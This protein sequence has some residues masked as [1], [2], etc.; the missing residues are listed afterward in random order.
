MKVSVIVYDD[1]SD[2]VIE[3]RKPSRQILDQIV[4][5]GFGTHFGKPLE[6]GYDLAKKYLDKS[7]NIIML[8]LSD[9]EADYP[10]N[11]ISKIKGDS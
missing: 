2:T 8:L 5:T 9:G 7:S 11:A 1:I 10:T 4:Y 6:D 3:Y